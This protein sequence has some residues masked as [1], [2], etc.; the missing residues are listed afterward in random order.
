MTQAEI[1]TKA[2]DLIDPVLGK[3]RAK[4][5]VRTIGTL[6]AVSDVAVLRRLWQPARNAASLESPSA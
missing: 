1:E 2:F 5:I 3:R 4:A 6:D